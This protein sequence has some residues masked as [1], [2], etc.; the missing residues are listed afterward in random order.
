[1]FQLDEK[2]AQDSHFVLQGPLCE[3]RLANDARFPWLIL[4]PHVERLTELHQLDDQQM[5]Q[6]LQESKRAAAALQQL[7]QPTKINVANLGNVVRQFHW[8]VVARFET[9]A[10]WPG[11]I[12]GN[13]SPQPYEKGLLEQRLT[14]LREALA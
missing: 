13:G 11:P 2:L 10:A 7:F 14:A 12:W 4:I 5:H 3:I 8:H 1:M 6:L 9:D